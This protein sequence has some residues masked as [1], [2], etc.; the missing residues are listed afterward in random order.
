MIIQKAWLFPPSS[1]A[2]PMMKIALKSL[3]YIKWARF[4]DHLKSMAISTIITSMT[5]EKC[6]DKFNVRWAWFL[7][8]T[9]RPRDSLWTA[10]EEYRPIFKNDSRWLSNSTDIDLICWCNCQIQQS[11][12]VKCLLWSNRCF[13]SKFPKQS[14]FCSKS[15]RSKCNMLLI[16]VCW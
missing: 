2:W 15:F 10:T 5:N 6:T 7:E 12:K 8:C 14:I 11:W 16:L 1:P 9:R 4:G 13:L 3:K